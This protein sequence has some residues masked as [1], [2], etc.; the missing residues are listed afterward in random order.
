MSELLCIDFSR[1]PAACFD[2]IYYN[3]LGEQDEEI[4]LTI[5]N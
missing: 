2:L 3:G 4:R 5:G 1:K